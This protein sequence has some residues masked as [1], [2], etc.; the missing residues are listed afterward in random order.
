[1]AWVH[2]FFF[3]KPAQVSVYVKKKKKKAFL[4]E[5]LLQNRYMKTSLYM[6]GETLYGV[7]K[8]CDLIM[9]FATISIFSALASKILLL[10]DNHS[11]Y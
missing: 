6:K 1:M 9:H 3:S 2:P 11:F 7:A 4:F 10:P 5:K 8:T